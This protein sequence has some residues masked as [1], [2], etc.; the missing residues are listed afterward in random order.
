MCK[1]LGGDVLAVKKGKT[2]TGNLFPMKNS[3]KY[4]TNHITIANNAKKIVFFPKFKRSF[5]HVIKNIIIESRR[6]YN[7][8]TAER[9]EQ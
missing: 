8:C 3:G 6:E 1:K 9:N 4:A 7:T 5:N 2:I